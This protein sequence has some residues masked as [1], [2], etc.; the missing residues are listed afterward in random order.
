MREKQAPIVQQRQGA[1]RWFED[2]LVNLNME[3]E[4]VEFSLKLLGSF[5]STMIRQVNEGV[6]IKRF[7]AD[8]LLRTARVRVSPAPCGKSG[9]R[10]NE[11]IQLVLSF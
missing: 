3:V 4:K 6:R 1:S 9:V 11:N 8:V 5:K 2:A 10:A 7:K